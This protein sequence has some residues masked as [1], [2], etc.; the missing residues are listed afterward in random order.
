[1]YLLIILI[2]FVISLRVIKVIPQRFIK[3]P[4][5]TTMKSLGGYIA[6]ILILSVIIPQV[7]L[8]YIIQIVMLLLMT[9][10]SA[11]FIEYW[12]TAGVWN[13]K[14]TGK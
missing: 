4:Y 8:N 6:M 11:L 13:T 7:Y 2:G 10:L 12:K 5:I 14:A 1:M 3:H 9:F